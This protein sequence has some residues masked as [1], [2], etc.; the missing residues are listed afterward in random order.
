M[1]HG[2]GAP[3]PMPFP[4]PL[5]GPPP[6]QSTQAMMPGFNALLQQLLFQQRNAPE[7]FRAPESGELPPPPLPPTGSAYPAPTGISF[8]PRFH[9]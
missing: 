4:P 9:G 7:A 3:P 2:P 8:T 6:P 1:N 5:P